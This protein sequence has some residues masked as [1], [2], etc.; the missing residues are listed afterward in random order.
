MYSALEAGHIFPE[1]QD[2]PVRR[3]RRR[4]RTAVT[5]PLC[6]LIDRK[7]LVSEAEIKHAMR[8][9]AASDRWIIEGAAGVALA[10]AI[11]LAPEYQ[12]KKWRWC[13]AV[14]HRA[15]EVLKAIADAH[16]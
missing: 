7:V 4:R 3:H 13:C 8:R 12:G 5:F 16:P 2:T 10:A 9:I 11:K 6:Q 15:G 1:E 14:K